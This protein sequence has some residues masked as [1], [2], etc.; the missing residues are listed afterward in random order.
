MHAIS[1]VEEI[2]RSRM[3]RYLG[4]IDGGRE[5]VVEAIGF[6]GGTLE[7]IWRLQHEQ[8]RPQHLQSNGWNKTKDP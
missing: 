5:S 7:V 2:Y 4:R 1:N 3:S 8:L 6:E